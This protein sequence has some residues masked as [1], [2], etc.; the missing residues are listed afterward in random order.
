MPLH[1]RALEVSPGYFLLPLTMVLVGRFYYQE[2]L[3]IVQ[4]LA[5]ACALMG[6][7]HELWMTGSF[8]WSTL[9]VALG[10]P[11]YFILRRKINA[12]PVVVF[13]LELAWGY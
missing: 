2:R 3:D 8:A 5:V 12:N 9:V 13:A 1:G 7:L 11:P 4:W 6:V 10:Y